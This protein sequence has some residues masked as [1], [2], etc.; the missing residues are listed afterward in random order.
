MDQW[1][2]GCH[3]GQLYNGDCGDDDDHR[4]N[5]LYNS[6]GHEIDREKGWSDD[7]A[8]HLK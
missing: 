6:K 8:K 4:T 2:R 3:N 5:Q 1:F 7:G